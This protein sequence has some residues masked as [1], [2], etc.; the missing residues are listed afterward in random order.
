MKL[1][2]IQCKNAKP[3]PKPSKS[4]RKLPDGTGLYLFV[5]PNG[6]K[7]WR[8]RYRNIEQKEKLMAFGVY[9][10]VSLLEARSQAQIARK[11][12]RQKVD[13]VAAVKERQRQ[14][15]KDAT[16]TFEIIAKE[17]FRTVQ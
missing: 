17:W 6:K 4:P 2:D 9:P 12:L 15:R 5:M 1:T 11:M 14:A 10:E 8:F 16:N 3:L 13:P 7:Y